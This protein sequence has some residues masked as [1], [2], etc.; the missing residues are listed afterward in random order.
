[1]T[2]YTFLSGADSRQTQQIVDLYRMGGWWDENENNPD[3]ID[4]IVQ[5]SHC[6]LAAIVSDQIIGMGRALSDGASDAYIQ[7][8]IVDNQFQNFKWAMEEEH[9][10]MKNQQSNDEQSVT[11]FF[12]DL[13]K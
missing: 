1:M 6:F 2:T 12:S 10:K 5:G 11:N 3:L 4:R 7:D 9:L 13:K 8:V